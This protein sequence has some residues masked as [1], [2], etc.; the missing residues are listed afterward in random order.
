MYP[1]QSLKGIARFSD[2]SNCVKIVRFLKIYTRSILSGVQ[3]SSPPH[4][5]EFKK[6][7]NKTY[8]TKSTKRPLHENNKTN[9]H[10]KHNSCKNRDKQKIYTHF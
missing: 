1:I 8:H 2:F 7:R 4:I 5:L 9:T 10:Q 6:N 3:N